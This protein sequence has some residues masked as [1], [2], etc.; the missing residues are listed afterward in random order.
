MGATETK[1]L[2]RKKLKMKQRWDR[3]CLLDLSRMG[4]VLEPEQ[5]QL[6]TT[7]LEAVAAVPRNE[8][9]EFMFLRSFQ[10]DH[11]QG[12]GLNLEVL[13]EDVI[14]L[15]DTGLIRVTQH[16]KKGSGFNFVVPPSA[17]ARFDEYKAGT[18]T[19]AVEPTAQPGISS[20]PDHAEADPKKVMVVHG[21]N[22]AAQRAM[23]EFLR[24]LGLKP[25]EWGDLIAGTGKAAPYVGEILDHAFRAATAVVVLFSPDDEGRLRAEFLEADDES[26]ETE[27]TPQ[28]RPNV[29]FEAGMA[30]AVHPDRTIL[31]EL[32]RLRPFSDVYGRH[33]V[34]LDGTEGP[35]IDISRRLSAAGCA[36]EPTDDSWKSPDRFPRA[37]IARRPRAG[38]EGPP[39]SIARKVGY[40]N[41]DARRWIA[42]RDSQLTG[43]MSQ[44]KGEMSAQ[45]MLYSGAYLVGLR[46]LRQQALQEYRDEMSRKR[47]DYAQLLDE[48]P[49]DA[50]VPLFELDDESRQ[51]LAGWRE[52][53][54]VPGMPDTVEIG[55]PTDISREPDLR[56]FE[57]E[58][59]G[60]G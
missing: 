47:R 22:R 13:F 38:E 52:P 24:D 9:Q 33:V 31:V 17:A 50:D 21:R 1:A 53:I 25:L 59:D 45:G 8:R 44:R 3:A 60:P 23:F 2:R 7:L 58:G 12:N 28:A 27:L 48:A 37:D 16:H 43:E 42:D 4:L 20:K 57:D 49:A 40:L 15:D 54:S 19:A 6:F 41:E 11:L 56:R 36:V 55:D 46:M 18:A 30:L 14:A 34:R 35:L 39:E 51:T 26:Y 5:E 10:A 29:L 32:G